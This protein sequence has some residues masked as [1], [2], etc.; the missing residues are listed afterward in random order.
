MFL[1]RLY[2]RVITGLAVLG[3]ASLVF[4]SLAIIVD[5]VLRSTGFR[6]FQS[7]SAIV[8][9]VMLFS[10]MA[11]APWLVRNNG[12]VAISSFVG[13][14]PETIRLVAGRVVLVRSG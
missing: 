13:A 10:T 4:I 6:P 7:T 1:I 11:A 5:V 12:H 8:E 2:N 14:L 9:Y 3:A